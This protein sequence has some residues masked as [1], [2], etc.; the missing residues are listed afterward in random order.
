MVVFLATA[1]GKNIGGKCSP[2]FPKE[3]SKE[4]WVQFREWKWSR[5]ICFMLKYLLLEYYKYNEDF[6][7]LVDVIQDY[8]MNSNDSQ[9]SGVNQR[10]NIN[11][12]HQLKNKASK[13]E[14]FGC[15]ML[16]IHVNAAGNAKKWVDSKGWGMWLHGDAYTGED[17]KTH[18]KESASTRDID[19]EL[20][21]FFY[22]TK[23]VVNTKTTYNLNGTCGNK[24]NSK[25]YSLGGYGILRNALCPAAMSENFLQD[26][27]D[28]VKFLR[29]AEGEKAVLTIHLNAIVAFL[30]KYGYERKTNFNP[31]KTPK[32]DLYNAP[33]P[34]H[35][36]L[37]GNNYLKYPIIFD[38]KNE[39]KN[40]LYQQD[41]NVHL[42]NKQY[43]EI[44][45]VIIPKGE[46]ESLYNSRDTASPKELVFEKM[47]ILTNNELQ[48]I[49]NKSNTDKT[50]NFK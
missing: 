31:T 33:N 25:R 29:S 11:K 16:T 36:D 30:K 45:K 48:N 20:C 6:D 42:F 34:Y 40:N 38:F 46:E 41:F 17:G 7:C 1:H 5:K 43:N 50:N 35:K 4:Q 3:G 22:H 27:Y 15:I 47:P 2:T 14:D 23:D 37:V 32:C 21:S 26:N 28:D 13:N 19:R 49:I 8:E 24:K 44:Y 12:Q 9:K 18:R 39:N 10:I